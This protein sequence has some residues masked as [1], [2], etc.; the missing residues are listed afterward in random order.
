M[1][2]ARMAQSS[3]PPAF[4]ARLS[5]MPRHLAIVVAPARRTMTRTRASQGGTISGMRQRLTPGDPD[6][7]RW[8]RAANEACAE[9]Y[10][11]NNKA[12]VLLPV[13][14]AI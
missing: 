12:A 6:A 5:G 13:F 11:S 4:E 14:P 3:T 1:P 8:V 2:N 9:G 10:F 7:A